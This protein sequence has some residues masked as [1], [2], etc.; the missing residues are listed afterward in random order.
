MT[1]LEELKLKVLKKYYGYDKFRPE[2]SR[3][4]NNVLAKK[5]S[6]VLMPTGGGKSLCFQIPAIMF[7]GLTIVISPLISLMQDQVHALQANGIRAEL[8]NSSQ[9]PKQID[10][11]LEKIKNNEL[12]LLYIAPERFASFGFKEFLQSIKISLIAI[13]EAHCISEWGHDFRTEYRNLSKLKSMF[14]DTPLI[15][16]TATATEKVKL[17][18]LKQLNLSEPKIFIT[19]FD[20]KNLSLQ[21]MKK[22]STFE[23]ILNL[24][25][26]YRNESV[27]IYCF[28][29]K[30]TESMAKK[31][32]EYNH[33]AKPYHAGLSTKIREKNQDDFIKDKVNII[34]ATIAFGMGIDKPDVR[35]VIHHTFSKSIEGYYQE[36]GRAGRDGLPS[37]CILFFSYGDKKKQEFLINMS[38]DLANKQAGQKKLNEMVSYCDMRQCRKKF[39]LSYF[40]E[41]TNFENNNCES[42]DV[43]LGIVEEI[44]TKVK[45]SK[46]NT[47]NYNNELFEEL[48]ILRI[49]IAQEKQIAPYIVFGDVALKQMATLF[50]TTDEGFMQIS[51]VGEKKLIDYGEDFLKII[52]EFVMVNNIEETLEQNTSSKQIATS[53]NTFD[54]EEG[55]TY[56]NYE[57]YVRPDK[58]DEE[59]VKTFSKRNRKTKISKTTKKRRTKKS[60]VTGIKNQELFDRLKV[61]RLKIADQRGAPAFTVFPDTALKDMANKKPSNNEQFL[62]MKGVGEKKLAEYGVRF[63]KEINN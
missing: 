32:K 10:E 23:K 5:D 50:P 6:L 63:L 47:G 38:R 62:E 40:G 53:E 55:V 56:K 42:C 24:L 39:L 17:D 46:V 3:I 59:T 49:E 28:S 57:T 33:N 9:T 41:Q 19:G 11:T 51:G 52:N 12:K 35:L 36:I 37:E 31:L 21:I 61:L 43:C 45:K 54:T 13:D 20:R 48:R 8:I 26:K 4:I 14:P 29:R 18:I 34:V 58:V 1:N 7:K 16:L 27:I 22:N 15:A 2:Q 30:D 60:G 44:P 25:E